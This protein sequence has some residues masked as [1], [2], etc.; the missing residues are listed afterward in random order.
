MQVGE[1]TPGRGGASVWTKVSWFRVIVT[2]PRG[3]GVKGSGAC[4]GCPGVRIRGIP[5]FIKVATQLMAD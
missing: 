4:R 2:H 3:C 5:E 1:V